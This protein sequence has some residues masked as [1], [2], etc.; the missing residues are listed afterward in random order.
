MQKQ[1]IKSFVHIYIRKIR[2]EAQAELDW[3][4]QQPTLASTIEYAALAVDSRGKRC[5]HQRRLKKSTLEQAKQ[6]LLANL[7]SIQMC[8]N[9]NDLFLLIDTLLQPISGAGEL[10]IY[11]TSLR[12]GVKLNL[13]PMVVY[14]HRGTRVGAEA[15]G[16]CSKFK[17]VEVSKL[18]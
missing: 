5:S 1:T 2:P 18:S 9:F 8:K 10:Y 17:T 11:D 14:L 6:D 13:L 15:L 4:R 7:K 3:F 16:V 12:I